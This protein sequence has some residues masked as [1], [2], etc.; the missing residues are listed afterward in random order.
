MKQKVTLRLPFLL[1]SRWNKFRSIKTKKA[2]D[3]VSDLLLRGRDDW[4]RTSGPHY[5]K[6]VR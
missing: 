2:T 1:Y 4:I 5:P 3:I 6:V